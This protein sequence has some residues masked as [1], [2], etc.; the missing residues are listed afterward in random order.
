MPILLKA[1]AGLFAGVIVGVLTV[2]FWPHIEPAPVNARP[3]VEQPKFVTAAVA[4]NPAPATAVVADKAAV[5]KL[6]LALR[7]APQ[8]SAAD[9]GSPSRALALTPT[10]ATE[11]SANDRALRLRAQGLVALAGGDVAAARA[12][13]ERAAEAGDARAL[14]VLGDTYDPATLTRMGA[15]GLKG[16]ASRAR[17]YYARALSAGV[18]AARDRIAAR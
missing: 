8:A 17:D 1:A 6:A 13:L 15:V 18:A 16:D 9:A 5:D 12:F 10:S 7:A 2:A 14:L 3:A 11:A 4:A